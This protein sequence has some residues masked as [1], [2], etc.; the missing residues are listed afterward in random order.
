MTR[1]GRRIK[2]NGKYNSLPKNKTEKR[3]KKRTFEEFLLIVHNMSLEE[4]LELNEY[5]KK[6]LDIEYRENYK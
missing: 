5:Q 6:A 1:Y 3:A 2:N 4:W